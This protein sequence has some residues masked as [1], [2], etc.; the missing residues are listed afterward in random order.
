MLNYT[1]LLFRLAVREGSTCYLVD[2]RTA[3]ISALDVLGSVRFGGVKVVST[4]SSVYD[5]NDNSTNGE[6]CCLCA[7]VFVCLC[8]FANTCLCC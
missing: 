8:V 4:A 7:T 6:P 1:S 3:H 5:N 2:E